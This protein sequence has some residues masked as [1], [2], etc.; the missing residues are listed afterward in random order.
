MHALMEWLNANTGA[1]LCLIVL[2]AAALIG[3]FTTRILARQTRLLEKRL[4][5]AER[6]RLRDNAQLLEKLSADAERA[7]ARLSRLSQ[8]LLSTLERDEEKLSQ[9]SEQVL[10]RQSGINAVL[11]KRLGELQASNERRLDKMRETVDQQL[12]AALEKRLSDSFRQVS[13]QLERVYRGLGEMQALAS[14]VGDLKRV[15]TGVKTRGIW[16]EV[17]LSALLEQNLAAGQYRENTTVE[18]GGT[19]R[20]EFAIVL[21]GK[22]DSNSVLLPVDSKY[23]QED[24]QRLID[25]AGR[26]DRTAV[27][28][29]GQALERAIMEQ[30]AKIRAKYI[31]VPYTTDFAIMFLPSEG[32]FA[33]VMRRA[34]LAEKLQTKYRIIPAGPS[35]FCALLNSLQ[36]GFRTLAVEK[37]TQEVWRILGAVREEFTRFGDA[38]DKT[39]QRLEQASSELDGASVRTRAISRQ[40]RAMERLEEADAPSPPDSGL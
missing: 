34:G 18:P 33:E 14:G 37:R 17:R 2:V 30:A 20:V 26:A 13:Q 24:Y 39:R 5:A 29:Y 22:E 19:D 3:F 10:A 15:L 4:D 36:M 25:A 31:R 16:G 12:G 35:T 8:S 40:L 1:A 27:E 32:L 11:E 38:L 23:P 7:E 28:K 9:L 21:P 6:R